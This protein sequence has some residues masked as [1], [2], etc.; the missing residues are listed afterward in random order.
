MGRR[1]QLRGGP[2]P[3]SHLV[4]D[5]EIQRAIRRD[6]EPSFGIRRPLTE[7]SA[8][9]VG[10][11]IFGLQEEA[12]IPLYPDVTLRDQLA[13]TIFSKRALG[14]K[15]MRG[16][17]AG[18][19]L[20]RMQARLGSHEACQESDDT[21]TVAVEGI[22]VYQNRLIYADLADDPLA[23]EIE[24]ACEIVEGMG[25]KG[26]A[27]G[28]QPFRP[29]LTLGAAERGRSISLTEQ[30]HVVHTLEAAMPDVVTLQGWESYPDNIFK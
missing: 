17:A 4:P 24:A 7:E 6:V 20:G 23:D 14:R 30:R 21:L 13:V 28:R 19:T 3:R 25:V 2:R 18:Y 10:K 26:M 15:V 12:D 5:Q 11:V 27:R 16:M 29:R 1:T 9:A 8:Q 22:G